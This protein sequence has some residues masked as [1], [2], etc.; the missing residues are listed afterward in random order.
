[1]CRYCQ[2]TLNEHKSCCLYIVYSPVGRLLENCPL[3][4]CSSTNKVRNL[5]SLFM[6]KCYERPCMQKIRRWTYQIYLEADRQLEFSQEN[7]SKKST[8][9]SMSCQ[10]NVHLLWIWDIKSNKLSIKDNH[11]IH[12]I[13]H[14]NTQS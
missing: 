2:Y 12:L 11:L 4:S 7:S 8:S 1:M 10:K 13:H 14:S 6:E 9:K 3:L 5:V